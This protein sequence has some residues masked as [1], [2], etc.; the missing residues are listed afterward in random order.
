MGW[1][2]LPKFRDGSSTLWKYEKCWGTYGEV[3]EELGVSRG[4]PRWVGGLRGGPG[5]LGGPSRRYGMRLGTLGEVRDA[6]WTLGE[7]QNGLL[8]PPKVPGRV[9]Y[10]ME[11]REMLGDPRG[12]LGRVGRNSGRTGTS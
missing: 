9:K 11:V 4:G 6:W 2:T 7:V 12:G 10:A 5:R 3:R 8:D 1:G